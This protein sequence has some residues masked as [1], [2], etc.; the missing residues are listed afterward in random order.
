MMLV[1]GEELCLPSVQ[2]V[3]DP[4][5]PCQAQEETWEETK[6]TLQPHSEAQWRTASTMSLFIA[7]TIQLNSKLF[8]THTCPY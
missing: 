1:W 5:S 7:P 4:E 8:D 3:S 6:L 2:R